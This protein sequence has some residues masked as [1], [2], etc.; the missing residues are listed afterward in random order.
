MSRFSYLPISL[1]AKGEKICFF[2]SRLSRMQFCILL[3]TNLLLQRALAPLI[4]P[5]LISPF[6]L[7]RSFLRSPSPFLTCLETPSTPPPLP[8]CRVHHF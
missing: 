4:I 1:C 2:P 3:Q 7:I 5:S 8:L 6:H